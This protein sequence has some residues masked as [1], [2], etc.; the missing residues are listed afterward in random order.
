M[1]IAFYLANASFANVDCKHIECGNPGIG[2]T[3]Y[4]IQAVAYFLNKLFGHHHKIILGAQCTDNTPEGVKAISAYNAADMIRKSD[5]EFDYIV[6]KNELSVYP[7]IISAI[8]EKKTKIVAWS[9]NFVKR[10]DNTALANLEKIVR[11]V[12][13]SE[14]QLQMYRDHRAFLKS[15]YIYNGMPTE[16][17]KNEF[18]SLL[19]YLSRPKEVTYVGSLVDYKGFHILAHAWK[20]VLKAVPDAHLNVI[21]SGKLYDRSSKLGRYGIAEEHYENKFM[22]YL[23]DEKGEIL[24]SVK[25][26]GVLGTE[27]NDVL[28]RTRV[29][30][31]NPSGVSETFCITALEM[32]AMGCLVTTMDFGGFRNTVYEKTG[33]LYKKTDELADNIIKLLRA[34]NKHVQEFYDYMESNFS[35][36]KVTKDWMALFIGLENNSLPLVPYCNPRNDKLMR[37]RET[38][39][40]IKSMVGYWLPTVDFYRSVL[41]RVGLVKGF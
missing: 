10:K 32:Q 9:H 24:P 38:N 39:R 21:G 12:N 41:R 35:F 13:V 28:K 1:N 40:R 5:I 30:V 37:I 20:S 34:D 26:W 15:S 7:D 33:V 14:E 36:E 23:T 8:G 16:I 19:P 18:S 3:E 31:P 17:W 4:M 27:K 6:I 25:F 2:G 22:Q 11:I 29:G